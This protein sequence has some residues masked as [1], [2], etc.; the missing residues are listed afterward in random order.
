MLALA[1]LSRG[2]VWI[3]LIADRGGLS[4]AALQAESAQRMVEKLEIGVTALCRT[5]DPRRPARPLACDISRHFL[6]AC[7]ARANNM[8]SY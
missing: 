4:D 6:A 7:G 5:S 1:G 8:R 2:H 3:Y